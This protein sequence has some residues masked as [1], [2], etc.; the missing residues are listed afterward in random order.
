MYVWGDSLVYM[1]IDAVCNI[2]SP[3]EYINVLLRVI[4][5]IQIMS[6]TLF[7]SIIKEL[8]L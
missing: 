1:H 4:L 7:C 2:V 5:P 6:L 3:S 8:E